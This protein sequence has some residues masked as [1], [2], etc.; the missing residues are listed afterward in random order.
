MERRKF[1][2]LATALLV[3]ILAVPSLSAAADPIERILVSVPLGESGCN[4][5]VQLQN[6]GKD[7]IFASISQSGGV[8][9]P[10]C[11]WNGEDFDCPDESCCVFIYEGWHWDCAG[12]H[13]I[14]CNTCTVFNGESWST[15]VPCPTDP[16]PPGAGGPP[17]C[18]ASGDFIYPRPISDSLDCEGCPASGPC[19]TE[20]SPG[21]WNCPPD[22]CKPRRFTEG[23]FMEKLGDASKYCWNVPA[24]TQVCK[25]CTRNPTTGVTTCVTQ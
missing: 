19:C 6:S 24:G 10:L 20:V 21:N 14:A 3:S 15:T 18:D 17:L 22:A 9:P 16:P 23:S 8:T 13:E 2:V 1:L 11:I 5:N 7:I 25:T 12:D 4:M